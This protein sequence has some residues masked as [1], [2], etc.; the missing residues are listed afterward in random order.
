MILILI[1]L[2][3]VVVVCDFLIGMMIFFLIVWIV[4]ELCLLYCDV[5]LFD[6]DGMFVDM[7]F[8]F[9]VVVNKM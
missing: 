2:L 5:V 7:V 4:D 8:D 3:C 9:V 1:I 6:L